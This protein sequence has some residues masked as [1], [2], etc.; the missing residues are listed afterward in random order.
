M[1]GGIKMTKLKIM[2]ALGFMTGF[3]I[4]MITFWEIINLL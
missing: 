4:G 2:F 3:V 1:V